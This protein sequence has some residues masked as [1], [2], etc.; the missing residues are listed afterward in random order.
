MKRFYFFLLLIIFHSNVFSQMTTGS[1]AAELSLP[2]MNGNLTSLSALKGK[3]VLI[4]F[5]ASWCG[6]CRRNNPHL[7]RLYQKY[8]GKGLEI[9][10]VS[11]DN[12]HLSW[13]AAVAHDKLG[14]IQVID[15]KGWDA[16]SALAYGVEMIPSSF[17][18]DKDG[19][20]RKINVEGPQLEK[21]IRML[22]K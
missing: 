10:G 17:L 18:I 6:P 9:Y 7:A 5:W 22:L 11:L 2:D 19:V 1:A 20:I 3:V 16:S 14:W 21:E 4:D 15:D 12:D 8:H 13:K